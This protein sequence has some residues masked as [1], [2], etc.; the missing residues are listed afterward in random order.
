LFHSKYARS[1]HFISATTTTNLEK[2]FSTAGE[3]LNERRTS[4]QPDKLKE[5][6]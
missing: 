1:S 6:Y 2:E 3:I 4:L 5:F